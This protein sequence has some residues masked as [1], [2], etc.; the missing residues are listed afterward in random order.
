MADIIY[1]HKGEYK[2]YSFTISTRNTKEVE[3][4]DSLTILD[5]PG[6]DFGLEPETLEQDIL[7]LVKRGKIELRYT[8]AS[9]STMGVWDKDDNFYPHVQDICPGL[10][11]SG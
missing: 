5:G 4:I 10:G 7:S 3:S 2:G 11:E 1:E 8:G 6:L 9:C